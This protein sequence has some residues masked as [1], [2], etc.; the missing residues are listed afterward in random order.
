MRVLH[1]TSEAVPF[2]KTG[3]LA[4]V[5]G[6][7]FNELNDIRVKTRLIMP[8]YRGI[9]SRFKPR[10]T[11]RS[12]SVEVGPRSYSSR[13][14]SY[15]GEVFFVECDE[16]FDRTE[17]YGTASE[18]FSDNAQR[19]VFFSK[20][21][22]EACITLQ[23]YPDIIH[24]HDWQTAL[25][26]LYAKTIYGSAFKETRTVF[27]IHNLGYQG[28]FPSSIMPDT[29]LDEGWF[30]YDGIEFYGNVNLLKAGIISADAITTV[31][32]NYA[33]EILTRE[34]GYGLDGV[35]Q[36]RAARLSGIINALDYEQWDPS[37][38]KALPARYSVES[39][40]G[41]ARCKGRL[42]AA[43]GFANRKAPLAG[44]VGRLTSQKGVDLVIG[45]IDEVVSMGFNVVVLG[46]GDDKYH[47]AF[48]EEAKKH[49]GRVFVN[50]CYDD[51]LARLIYA[52]SDVFLMPSK[53]EPCGLAQMIAMR[54]GTVPVARATG[55][56]K[57]TIADYNHRSGRGT[58]FLF[59]G[60][61]A[62]ALAECLKRAM[63]V[64]GDRA[65]WKRLV[66]ECMKQRFSW[67]IAARK[68][69]R[70]YRRLLRE[71]AA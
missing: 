34:Y 47:K 13:I 25:V 64:Y 7:L 38:D 3:G 15:R 20:A 55:G 44:M 71:G 16:F 60:Y 45:A 22:L 39:T 27:T 52:G 19:F 21:V 8:L 68:Y 5:T 26:P 1:A 69:A 57:D 53:Y 35:L 32:D 51:K 36:K 66:A 23:Y 11:G 18:E 56:I 30:T 43:C 46:K 2:A 65:R 4:D 59:S 12:I 50:L 17:L 70:L 9:K 6:T 67:R 63:C 62:S 40:A 42:V 49:G 10:D 54:Y 58:G 31:S 41:K 29:G 28:I 48:K 61:D 33:K 14:L 37:S 24:C